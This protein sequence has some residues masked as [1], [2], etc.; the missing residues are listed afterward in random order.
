MSK[1][2]RDQIRQLN[3]SIVALAGSVIKVNEYIKEMM[4]IVLKEQERLINIQEM[5]IIHLSKN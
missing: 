4:D 2:T 5:Y 3:V 1:R